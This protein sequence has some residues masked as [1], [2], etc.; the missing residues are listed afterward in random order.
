MCYHFQAFYSANGIGQGKL[1][2]GHFGRYRDLQDLSTRYSLNFS[3]SVVMLKTNQDLYD[4]G[5]M[6]KNAQIFGAGMDTVF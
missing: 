3:G 2:Y 1:V 6:V 5:S 4:V